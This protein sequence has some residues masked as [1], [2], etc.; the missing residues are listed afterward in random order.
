MARDLVT[1]PH[2]K[3]HRP[4]RGG[5]L[6]AP[7]EGLRLNL[8]AE[9]SGWGN[10]D[11]LAGLAMLSSVLDDLM[12]QEVARRRHEGHTWADIGASLGVTRQAAHLRYGSAVKEA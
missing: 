4:H 6:V 7:E 9:A 8:S 5:P 10:G 3:P 2:F 11:D 1:P 12:T